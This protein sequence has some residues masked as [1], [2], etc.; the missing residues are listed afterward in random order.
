M[1]PRQGGEVGCVGVELQKFAYVPLIEFVGLIV[2]DP[3]Q[4]QIQVPVQ[5]PFVPLQV[6]LVFQQQ[7]FIEEPQVEF[8]G[9]FVHHPEQLQIQGAVS[10]KVPIALKQQQLVGV[11]QVEVVDSVVEV[12]QQEF[13]EKP[14]VEFVKTDVHDPVQ[15]QNQVAV[16]LPIRQGKAPKVMKQQEFVEA[17]QVKMLFDNGPKHMRVQVR[18][19]D[20]VIK[21]FEDGCCA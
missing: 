8:V 5:V 20:E 11:P 16:P 19:L 15:L 13:V 14:Q 4:V 17:P 21:N 12:L 2:H 18:A 6:P 9:S 7:K 10:I 3:L 1:L